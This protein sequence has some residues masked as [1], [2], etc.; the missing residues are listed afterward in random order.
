MPMVTLLF[1]LIEGAI[2][3]IMSY[4]KMNIDHSYQKGRKGTGSTT[5]TFNGLLSPV[6]LLQKSLIPF[7]TAKK[8]IEKSITT[9]VFIATTT[10]LATKTTVLAKKLIEKFTTTTVFM[11]TT[12]VL[13]IKTTVLVKKVIEISSTTTVFVVKTIELTAKTTVNLKLFCRHIANLKGYNQYADWFIKQ[14]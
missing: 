12:T 3:S 2:P 13:V 4:W 7:V 6:S 11:A 1:K 5:Y 14:R 10:V 8:V 9:T